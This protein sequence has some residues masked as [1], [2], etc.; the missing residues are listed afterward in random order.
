MVEVSEYKRS[1]VSALGLHQVLVDEQEEALFGLYL[2]A[3]FEDLEGPGVNGKEHLDV[4]RLRSLSVF[5]M[6]H[7]V[8]GPVGPDLAPQI[9]LRDV[10]SVSEEIEAGEL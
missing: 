7:H 1:L 8:G 2:I 5:H 4:P 3:L 9:L 10:F 6:M